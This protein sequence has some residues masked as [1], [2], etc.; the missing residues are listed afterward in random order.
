MCSR[1]LAPLRPRILPRKAA[2]F[3]AATS[4]AVLR[5]VIRVMMVPV[6]VFC[7]KCGL[8]AALLAAPLI[9]AAPAAAGA[10]A[11]AML[12]AMIYARGRAGA[13]S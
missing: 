8:F 2:F 9:H 4:P 1:T 5:M 13:P 11:A 6:R 10:A 12:V 3:R 7:G